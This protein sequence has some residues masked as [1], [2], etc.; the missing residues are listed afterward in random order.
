MNQERLQNVLNTLKKDSDCFYA[1]N[2]FKSVII[3]GLPSAGVFPAF[4]VSVSFY[5]RRLRYDV[6]RRSSM[7]D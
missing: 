5:H 4:G 2:V 3:N 6:L 7:T 1:K